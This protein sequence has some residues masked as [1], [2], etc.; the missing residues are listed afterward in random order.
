MRFAGLRALRWLGRGY[1]MN[2][3]P[4]YVV[5]YPHVFVASPKQILFVSSEFPAARK[6]QHVHEWLLAFP[7]A[8]QRTCTSVLDAR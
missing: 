7:R 6:F 2:L 3:D 8:V 4:C 5:S 1:Y